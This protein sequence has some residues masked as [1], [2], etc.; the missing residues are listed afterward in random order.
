M[1][2]CDFGDFDV[3]YSRFLK[4]EG[5]S[6]MEKK[7]EKGKEKRR[8]KGGRRRKIIFYIDFC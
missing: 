2:M 8:E 1:A 4:R 5:N 6:M 7:K 3:F